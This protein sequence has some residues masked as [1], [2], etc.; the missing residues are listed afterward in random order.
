MSEVT[1]ELM[2]ELLKSIDR[3]LGQLSQ[4]F[5]EVKSEIDSIR[6][7]LIATE[8]DVKNTYGVLS[9]RGDRL[10]RIERRLEGA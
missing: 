4:G 8:I 3:R 6:G 5:S 2:F 9:R 10:E 7:H 1:N